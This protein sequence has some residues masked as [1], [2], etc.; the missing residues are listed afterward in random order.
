MV[1]GPSIEIP[2]PR[3]IFDASTVY[4]FLNVVETVQFVLAK[5]INAKSC[6]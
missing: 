2:G 3:G 1:P 4:S 6:L 5:T